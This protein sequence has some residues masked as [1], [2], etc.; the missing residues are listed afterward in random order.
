MSPTTTTLAELERRH[1]PNSP[2]VASFIGAA[3]AENGGPLTD[4][5]LRDALLNL[6]RSK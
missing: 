2:A 3:I 6:Q 4:E 1:S 5:Q